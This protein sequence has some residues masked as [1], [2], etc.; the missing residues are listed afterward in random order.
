MRIAQ[1][2][3]V[4]FWGALVL[5]S[6]VSFGAYSTWIRGADHRDLYPRWA[7]ARMVLFDGRDPYS[8]ETTQQMQVR[9]YGGLLPPD[10]DQQAFAYPAQLVILLLPLWFI[11]NVEVAT[12]VWEGFSVLLLIGALY[13]LSRLRAKPLPAWLGAGLLLWSYPLLMI[14]QGQF[15]GLVLAAFM[16]SLAAFCARRDGLAGAVIG[17]AV[18]KPELALLPWITL[19][20]LAARERRWRVWSA[21][22]A[23]Q[24]GL[25]LLSL[26]IAGWWVPGWM[27]GIARYAVYAKSEWALQTAWQSSPLLLVMILALMIAAA[28][29]IRWTPVLLFTASIALS[30]L[31]LPQTMMWNLTLLI[32]PLALSWK[33]SARFA[34]AAAWLLGWVM[35][36]NGS[37]WRLQYILLPCASLLSML[38][39][40]SRKNE[41][42]R[43]F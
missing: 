33:G 6:A 30:L 21:F 15:T 43:F 4:Y 12:A 31:V 22:F 9:L 8:I 5:W 17:I 27:Y 3:W 28:I 26:M 42:I 40:Y 25:F 2:K 20:F 35:L 32:A 7:V 34:V 1:R 23:F 10:H 13:L 29:R 41:F 11:D 19:L 36:L 37:E 38:M 18:I 24:A 16:A 14:F 39:A